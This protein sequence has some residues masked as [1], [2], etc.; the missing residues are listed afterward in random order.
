[1]V[2]IHISG[3]NSVTLVE[4]SG[5]IDSM[6]AHELGEALAHEIDEG[7][8]HLVLDLSSVD[9]MSSAGLREIVSSLK[10]AKKAQISGEKGDLR[11]ADPSVRVREVLE[12]SGLDTI[13]KIYPSQA[14]AVE[15]Y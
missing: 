11:L 3:Q 9:F 13:F 6:N 4:A 15:S 14:D 10:K 12:M 8:I 2:D 5:R 1:M 7:N